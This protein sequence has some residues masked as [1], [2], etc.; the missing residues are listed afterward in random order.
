MGG[1]LSLEYSVGYDDAHYTQT[2]LGPTPTNGVAASIL[3][4][5]GDTFPVPVWTGNLGLSYKFDLAQRPS[6]ARVDWQYQGSYLRTLG[7]GVNSFAPDVRS[8]S[9]VT[10]INARLGIQ[11]GQADLNLFARNLLDSRTLL[12]EAGGRGGCTVAT[13]AACTTYT[14]YGVFTGMSQRPREIGAQVTYKF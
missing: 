5:A 2:A 8:A 13:G 9:S 3:V 4:H 1:G 6:Y 11:L 14:S 10:T 12:T 7:P